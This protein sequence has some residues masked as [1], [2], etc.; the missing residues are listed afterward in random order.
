[1]SIKLNL[2]SKIVQNIRYLNISYSSKLLDTFQTWDTDIIAI[3]PPDS[4]QNDIPSKSLPYVFARYDLD[5][6]FLSNFWLS[7]IMILGSLV[8]S[9]IFNVI[10]YLTENSLASTGLPYKSIKF[11]SRASVNFF[12]VQLYGS[13]D[14][15]VFFSILEVK[16]MSLRSSL[17]NLSFALT[18]LFLTFVCAILGFQSYILLSFRSLRNQALKTHNTELL[19]RFQKKYEPVKILFDDFEES[20]LL[21]QGFLAL[22]TA[23]NLVLGIALTTLY[24]Y[25]LAQTILFFIL[26]LFILAFLILTK[27]FKEFLAAASQYFCEGVLIVVQL[28]TLIMAMMDSGGV[29]GID[30]RNRLGDGIFV[31]NIILNIGG[32]IFLLVE[33]LEVIFEYFLARYLRL[34][35]EKIIELLLKWKKQEGGSFNEEIRLNSGM[36]RSESIEVNRSGQVGR[37]RIM[38]I[39][40]VDINRKKEDVNENFVEEN[41]VM[42]PINTS[43]IIQENKQRRNLIKKPRIVRPLKNSR[44]TGLE[45]QRNQRND[46]NRYDGQQIRESN[47]EET[48]YYPQDIRNNDPRYTN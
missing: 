41:S 30:M 12:L 39:R 25:P 28:S 42:E 20:S 27:P 3:N 46:E 24:E 5:P 31:V 16:S 10:R 1:M 11:T 7:L 36:M 15:I 44:V 43:G 14:D 40:D 17:A 9:I 18:L 35:K 21:Q 37:R 33:T 2:I 4:L 6:S 48:R 47:N 29:D 45:I 8:V 13:L 34:N 32:M 26:S 38:N 23:R 22:L 19:E